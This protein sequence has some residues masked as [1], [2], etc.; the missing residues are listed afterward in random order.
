MSSLSRDQAKEAI[1]TYAW[2]CI[3]GAIFF[4][5][6][7]TAIAVKTVLGRRLQKKQERLEDGNAIIRP[8][9]QKPMEG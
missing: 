9:V 6:I 2:V 4:V 5:L 1:S 8:I 7:M 3:G